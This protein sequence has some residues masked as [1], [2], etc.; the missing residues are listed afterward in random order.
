MR[1]ERWIKEIIFLS[2]GE[3]ELG[4]LKHS[5]SLHIKREE[6]GEREQERIMIS[7]GDLE[8]IFKDVS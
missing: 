2:I 4:D 5:K 8:E 6:E 7:C 3:P 1:N